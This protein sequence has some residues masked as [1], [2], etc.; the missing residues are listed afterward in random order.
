MDIREF[1]SRIESRI[2]IADVHYQTIRCLCYDAREWGMHS[3]QVFPNMVHLC[4]PILKDTAV[5]VM[6][7]NAW[8]YNGFIGGN[9]KGLK[10]PALNVRAQ[11]AFKR[12]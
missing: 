1:S 6:A 2:Y 8:S 12:W 11:M 7:L 4:T 3:V 10:L 5:K 9:R